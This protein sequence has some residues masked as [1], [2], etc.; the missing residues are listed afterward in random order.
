M[1]KNNQKDKNVLLKLALQFYLNNEDLTEK[2]SNL[3]SKSS[4]KVF[5]RNFVCKAK[6]KLFDKEKVFHVFKVFSCH[7]SL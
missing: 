2:K 7:F 1:E 4:V 3:F 5:L 6:A